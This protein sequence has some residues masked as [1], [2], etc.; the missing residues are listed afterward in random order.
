MKKVLAT[1]AAA[2][3][4]TSAAVALADESSG[5]IMMIDPATKTLTLEDGTVYELSEGV[6]IQDL[7]PGQEVTVSYEVEGG[8]NVADSVAVQK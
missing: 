2:A 8:K 6:A 1:L 5:K 4:M 3:L 7:R